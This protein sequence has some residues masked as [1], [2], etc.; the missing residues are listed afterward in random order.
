MRLAI[1]RYDLGIEWNLIPARERL[2]KQLGGFPAMMRPAVRT[3]C[4]DGKGCPAYQPADAFRL[5]GGFSVRRRD[6]WTLRP[7]SISGRGAI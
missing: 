4:S 6:M 2:D 7:A 3:E 5:V 1:G